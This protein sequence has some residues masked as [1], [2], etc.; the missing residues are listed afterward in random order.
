M[1]AARAIKS[2]CAFPVHI[3]SREHQGV[4]KTRFVVH[5]PVSRGAAAPNACTCVV[6]ILGGLTD[7]PDWRSGRWWWRWYSRF[8]V[9]P[10]EAVLTTACV[11]FKTVEALSAVLAWARPAF[12]DTDVWGRRRRVQEES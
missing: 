12:V 4:D 1:V 3:L 2:T 8:A 9:Q 11:C 10:M 6:A 5:S 7:E